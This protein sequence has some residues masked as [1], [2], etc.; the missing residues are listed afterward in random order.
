MNINKC[1]VNSDVQTRDKAFGTIFKTI[2]QCI[3]VL[4]QNVCLRQRHL[5]NRY[6]KLQNTYSCVI[7]IWMGYHEHFSMR[8]GKK[9][10][11]KDT[12]RQPKYRKMTS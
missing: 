7:R 6:L 12:H 2:R 8:K 3:T 10:T 5:S 9:D 11:L 1:H 4:R